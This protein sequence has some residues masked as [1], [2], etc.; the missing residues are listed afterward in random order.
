MGDQDHESFFSSMMLKNIDSQIPIAFDQV[1]PSKTTI[2]TTVSHSSIIEK[3]SYK[4]KEVRPTSY[5]SC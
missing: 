3:D 5:Q 4:D 1:T 2:P